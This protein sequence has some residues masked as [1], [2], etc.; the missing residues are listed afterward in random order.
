M[1]HLFL[2]D[3]LS[4]VDMGGG[5]GSQKKCDLRDFF[6]ELW[7]EKLDEMYNNPRWFHQKYRD[8]DHKSVEKSQRQHWKYKI[9]RLRRHTTPFRTKSAC[10]TS[11]R[12]QSA[13]LPRFPVKPGLW[14][15]YAIYK[16][17]H[18]LRKLPFRDRHDRRVFFTT[19]HKGVFCRVSPLDSTGVCPSKN[20]KCVICRV[21]C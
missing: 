7:F 15:G 1:S 8:S 13:I 5:G 9:F 6:A 10:F 20:H 14:Q 3:V 4:T 11:S 18:I 12:S 21:S 17:S 2:E 16:R 19:D